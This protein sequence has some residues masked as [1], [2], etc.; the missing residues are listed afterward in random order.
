[1]SES[2][3]FDAIPVFHGDLP[4]SVANALLASPIVAVD[5]E[6]SGLSWAVDRLQ[7]CQLFSPTTG[8]VLLRPGELPPAR[9]LELLRSPATA[10]VFHF[11]PFDLRFLCA[12]WNVTARNVRCTKT[13]HKLLR[14][15]APSR[16]HSLGELVRFYLGIELDKGNVRTSD[17]GAGSLSEI[18]VAYAAADVVHLIP[19]L[20]MLEAELAGAGKS[21]LFDAVC[22]YLPIAVELEIDGM[23]DPLQY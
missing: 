1:M 23:P 17:W 2:Q 8:A 11:A 14:P 3:R 5:T 7:L 20:E 13:A 16:E 15:T 21:E 4:T 12:A 22:S 18:Q 10:K 9:L 6:T 19:L